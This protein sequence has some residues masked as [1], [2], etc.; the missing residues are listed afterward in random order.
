M[1]PVI[2]LRTVGQGFT[3]FGLLLAL[4][5]VHTACAAGCVLSGHCP[6]AARRRTS[7]HHRN[8]KPAARHFGR[9]VLWAGHDHCHPCYAPWPQPP[10]DCGAGPA[11]GRAGV[12]CPRQPWLLSVWCLVQCGDEHRLPLSLAV[13]IGADASR[14]TTRHSLRTKKG[15]PD[16][17]PFICISSPQKDRA[18][19]PPPPC[20]RPPAS[21]LD[22]GPYG[23]AAHRRPVPA[24]PPRQS[25]RRHRPL[26]GQCR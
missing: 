24:C 12:V 15:V 17:T 9:V 14:R 2:L 18:A 8:R 5:G 10:A 13:A 1:S 19:I 23:C 20:A 11:Y 6:P 26:Q 16:G 21:A 25:P 4:G 22:S 7:H 3:V